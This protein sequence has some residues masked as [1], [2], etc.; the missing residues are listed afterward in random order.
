MS[1]FPAWFNRAYK[2]WSRSQAGEEDFIAFSDLLG[3]PPSKVLGWLHG[4]FL[5]EEPEVLSIAGIFGTDVY[6]VLDLPKPE[7]QLLE[8]YKSFAHITGENRGK[9]V[10]ALW[11]AQ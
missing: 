10:H 8:I 5:P 1:N 7:P 3:Y 9:I 4:E 2:R 11:E 6:E